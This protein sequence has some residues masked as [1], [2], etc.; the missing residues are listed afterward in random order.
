MGPAQV[1]QQ[2]TETVNPPGSPRNFKDPHKY[3]SLGSVW[4]E[5][6]NMRAL[7]IVTPRKLEILGKTQATDTWA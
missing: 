4:V 5:P 3:L 6:L 7:I 2:M 1:S